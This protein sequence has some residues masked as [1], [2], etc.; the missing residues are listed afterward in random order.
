MVVYI[1]IYGYNYRIL[2]GVYDNSLGLG[3]VYYRLLIIRYSLFFIVDIFKI[4]KF[5][6][7]LIFVIL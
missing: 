5:S 3:Y 1:K 6:G 4:V 2:K 7:G